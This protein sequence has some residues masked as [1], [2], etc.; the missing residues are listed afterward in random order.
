[1][2]IPQQTQRIAR[3]ILTVFRHPAYFGIEPPDAQGT[4]GANVVHESVMASW[5]WRWLV[6]TDIEHAVR[7]VADLAFVGERIVANRTDK[8]D[9]ELAEPPLAELPRT[10]YFP[11]LTSSERR[12]TSGVVRALGRREHAIAIAAVR[13]GEVG[14]SEIHALETKALDQLGRTVQPL[15]YDL[16][17]VQAQTDDILPWATKIRVDEH[18]PA[19]I[20]L[21]YD[22]G[23][24]EA[25]N[26]DDMGNLS[27]V[28]RHL[29]T[30]KPQPEV[31]ADL[32]TRLEDP[33]PDVRVNV[34]TLLGM[35]AYK[36]GFVPGAELAPRDERLEPATLQPSTIEAVLRLARTEQHQGVLS[37]IV[38]TLKSQ[39][40]HGRLE[41]VRD[42]V[43]EV[44]RWEIMPKLT[45]ESTLKDCGILLADVTD[46]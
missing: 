41:V 3:A 24:Q 12:M 19:T 40:Y 10:L 22:L 21:C 34:L 18:D 39:A 33:D 38:C 15:A 42:R 44:V 11:D 2:I 16:L 29:Y 17:G 25:F 45:E 31:E 6:I 30:L 35:P 36:V 27:D 4:L 5:E 43:R 46:G 13:H 14:G 23:L 37:N 1:M 28:G 8:R 32:L 9:S 26:L 7:R 20:A